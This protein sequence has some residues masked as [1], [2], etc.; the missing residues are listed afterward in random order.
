MSGAACVVDSSVTRSHSRTPAQKPTSTSAIRSCR[1]S[2]MCHRWRCLRLL[3]EAPVLPDELS[4]R[5]DLAL[6]SEI[7]DQIEMQ[8]GP[9]QAS[10][11]RE[12]HPERQVHRPADLLVEE[13]VAGKPVDLV[14]EAEGDLA[15]TACAVIQLEQRLQVLLSPAGLRRDHASFLESQLYVV[16]LTTTEDGGKPEPDRAVDARFDGARV[17]LTVREVPQSVCGPPGSVRD[18]DR[19]ISVLADDP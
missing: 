11:T 8:R 2:D 13:D 3:Q 10:E 5:I 6:S 14:V 16:D 15:D 9:V 1:L 17:D 12:A 19:Q 4:V 7:A 18:D